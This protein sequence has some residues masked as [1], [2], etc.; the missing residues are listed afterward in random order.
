MAGG[1]RFRPVT[2]PPPLLLFLL[3]AF[4]GAK[5][6][7]SVSSFAFNGS[8][9]ELDSDD[10]SVWSGGGTDGDGSIVGGDGDG[11]LMS[12]GKRASRSEERRST[13]TL[14]FFAP[15]DVDLAVMAVDDIAG[16]VGVD[17]Y[18]LCCVGV[19]VVSLSWW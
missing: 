8:G 5:E 12:D 13:I 19:M 9:V 4:G 14:L 15:F 11:G 2:V 6:L 18:V 16:E 7:A 17:G 10:F 3:S 1:A